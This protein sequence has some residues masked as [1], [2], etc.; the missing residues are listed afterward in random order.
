MNYVEQEG[1]KLRVP[2]KARSYEILSIHLLNLA[3]LRIP[4]SSDDSSSNANRRE[5][6]KWIILHFKSIEYLLFSA[7]EMF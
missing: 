2:T 6:K 7:L 1:L 3:L 4:F 5:A